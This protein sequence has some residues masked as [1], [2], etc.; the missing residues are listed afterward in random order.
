M[1][2]ANAASASP[3]PLATPEVTSSFHGEILA[4]KLKHT[5]GSAYT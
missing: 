4:A 5:L 1:G 2:I 3:V